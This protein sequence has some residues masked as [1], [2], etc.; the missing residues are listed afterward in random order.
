MA[1]TQRQITPVDPVWD[2]ITREARE[3]VQEAPLMGGLVH[4][5]VLHHS[6]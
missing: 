6:S 1:E 5:C 2:R 3:A 4:A